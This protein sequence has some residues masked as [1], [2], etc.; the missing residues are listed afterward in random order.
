MSNP[1]APP[2]AETPRGT[3]SDLFELPDAEDPASKVPPEA[4]LGERAL[5]KRSWREEIQ[6]VD[7]QVVRSLLGREAML[8]LRS[9]AWARL[10][11][12]F[13]FGTSLLALL[14]I[15]YRMAP[16]HWHRPTNQ[17]WFGIWA[18][19][20]GLALLSAVSG[21]TRRRI[22]RELRAG[23]LEEI[24]LTG[25]GPAD[26]LL[27]KSIATAWMAGLLVLV[28]VPPGILAAAIGGRDLST[29]LRVS[30]TLVCCA[31]LGLCVGLE[32]SFRRPGSR[33]TFG[34]M[35]NWYYVL[36]F[37]GN[38]G[39]IANWSVLSLPRQWIVRYN[40]ISTLFAA[41]GLRPERWPLGLLLFGLLLVVLTLINFRLLRSEWSQAVDRAASGTWFRRL[42][43]PARTRPSVSELPESAVA[44]A[45][46]QVAQHGSSG[47]PP[48]VV[49]ADPTLMLDYGRNPLI[50]FERQFGHH[51]RVRRWVWIVAALVVAVWLFLPEPVMGRFLF[52]LLLWFTCLIAAHNGCAPFAQERDRRGW[53]ELALLPLSERELVL[54][55]ITAGV[56]AWLPPLA[57][58]AVSLLVSALRTQ[59]EAS[60][61]FAWG[62]GSLLL[63]P[64]A[65]LALGAL[66]G[67]VNHTSEEA[68][69]RV[70]LISTGLPALLFT[71]SSFGL[72][73]AGAEVLCP[74]F[75]ALSGA[76]SG[77]AG[78]AAW[79]GTLLYAAAGG[80]A[81]WLVSTRLRSWA[82]HS[83]A[84]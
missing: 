13:T 43:R 55:K 3:A 81:G 77:Y 7:W 54:G 70:A 11:A 62:A 27:G 32:A 66:I 60:S 38:L 48:K 39:R 36:L 49:P 65:Y 31:Y 26:I 67:L 46:G 20:T 50:A 1:P 83:T 9:R 16:G 23:A 6:D 76:P 56:G 82:L 30:V 52:G 10:L 59:G 4:N 69:W 40:P 45:P 64:P 61:W 78:V 47:P 2:P 79:M 28:A 29:L 71:G 22:A 5:P 37:V 44:V 63:L 51:L 74:L 25:S 84:G 57:A 17:A 33:S 15:L 14:P 73:L 34:R 41:T 80:I 35:W 21:W 8:T 58:A 75:A 19:G 68:H 12:W 18:L 24:L 42:F 53:E 72:Q